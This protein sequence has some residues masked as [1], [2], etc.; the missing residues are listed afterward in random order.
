MPRNLIR[1][2]CTAA[3][4]KPPP[5]EG[6]PRNS[7]QLSPFHPE[8]GTQVDGQSRTVGRRRGLREHVGGFRIPPRSTQA[9]DHRGRSLASPGDIR[10]SCRP[11][12]GDH[13]AEHGVGANFN[14]RIHAGRRQRPDARLELDRA[15]GLPTPVGLIQRLRRLEGPARDIAHKG[16]LGGSDPQCGRRVP[17]SIQDRIHQGTVV[18]GTR[19]KTPHSNSALAERTLDCVD[20]RDGTANHLMRRVVG[21]DCQGCRMGLPA[22]IRH[23]HFHCGPRRKNRGHGSG[24]W[25][26]R[27][28]LAA[29]CR[30]AEGILPAHRTGRGCRRNLAQAVTNHNGRPNTKTGPQLRQRML[31]RENRRLCPGGIIQKA[32]G[33]GLAEH[34]IQQRPISGSVSLHP[35]IAP[36]QGNPEHRLRCVE[37]SS[38][39][40]PLTGLAREGEGHG[41][42]SGC[43]NIPRG[44]RF[45]LRPQCLGIVKDQCGPERKAGPADTGGPCNVRQSLHRRFITNASVRILI[46]EP[47]RVAAGQINDGLAGLAGQGQH[48]PRARPR[49]PTL[50]LIGTGR[51]RYGARGP[52]RCTDRVDKRPASGGSSPMG[53]QDHMCVRARPAERVDPG[54]GRCAQRDLRPGCGAGRHDDGQCVPCHRRIRILEMQVR[55][56]GAGLQREGGLDDRGNT[57][58]GFQVS[59]VG[60]DGADVE[61][62]VPA[63][64]AP[65]HRRRG[66]EL[67]G[68]ANLGAGAVGFDIL[69]IQGP[70]AGARQ[71]GLND[72]PLGRAVRHRE[73]LGRTVL[74]HGAAP[75]QRPDATPVG[76][77]IRQALQHHNAAP[78]AAHIAVGGGIER[79]AH[80]I[81]GQHACPRP[82]LGQATGEDRLDAGHQG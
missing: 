27:H 75:N 13:G 16:Q 51:S 44:E 71:S 11:S 31:Q 81:R 57:G 48:A 65:V 6:I 7:P 18:A 63:P 62:I 34:D 73:P 2:A 23:R 32:L 20:G 76:F 72:L 24:F 50:A 67:D 15:A 70:Y 58:C 12:H 49:R 35:C 47:R 43:L 69:H 10:G 42:R 36:V 1:D 33:P 54:H 74:I 60:L 21:R 14:D 40:R 68:V 25:Q 41:T 30:E 9:G 22:C 82:P 78:F 77:R 52:G 38:H 5:L 55:G 66:L 3:R 19:T 8:Q 37:V 17:Q 4:P 26:L 28:Q 80:P 46:F 79:L 61:R 64:S 45:Q 59:K 29:R 56:D 53:R 39:A